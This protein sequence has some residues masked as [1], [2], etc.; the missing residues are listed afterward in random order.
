[1]TVLCNW[2]L[3]LKYQLM[4]SMLNS[5]LDNFYLFHCVDGWLSVP[6]S[7]L[8]FLWYVSFFPGFIETS[9]FAKLSYFTKN[10]IF[11]SYGWSSYSFLRLLMHVNNFLPE[12]KC[13]FIYIL[14]RESY[15]IF[16]EAAICGIN[17]IDPFFLFTCCHFNILHSNIFGIIF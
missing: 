10:G 13:I 4:L 9:Y 14:T 15:C 6:F 7:N 12:R 2:L 17:L 5:D 16:E 8:L 3:Q 11:G 1:M